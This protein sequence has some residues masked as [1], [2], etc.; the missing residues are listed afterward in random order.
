MAITLKVT[1]NDLRTKAY[2]TRA[3]ISSLQYEFE[4]IQDIISKTVGYWTGEAGDKARKEF[5]DQKDDTQMVIKRFKEHPTD[6]LV[7]AGV[8][9]STEK[10]VVSVNKSL[11]TDVIV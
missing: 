2:E 5:N 1:P 4:S 7:M 3:K 10:E 6:L 8:Y 9:E 11:S